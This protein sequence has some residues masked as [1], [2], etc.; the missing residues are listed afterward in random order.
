MIRGPRWTLSPW[1]R[2]R[3]RSYESATVSPVNRFCYPSSDAV[4]LPR[5][6]VL[7]GTNLPLLLSEIASTRNDSAP[8]ASYGGA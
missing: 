3:E 7:S 6:R 2:P 8:P 1:S 4:T 5:P